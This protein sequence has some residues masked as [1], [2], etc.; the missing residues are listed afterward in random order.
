MK[1]VFFSLMLSLAG[2]SAMAQLKEGTV[3]YERKVNVHRTITDEQMRAMIPE[4]RTSKHMLMFSDSVSLFRLLPEDEAPDP[5]AGG[6]GGRVMFRFGGNTDGGD[7]YK[8]L[9]QSKSVLTAELA[10]KNYLI[11][12][13]IRQLPWKLTGETKQILGYT[14]LKATRKM[15]VSIAP[16]RRM[17]V[18]G[19][20]IS[21]NNSTEND[22]PQQKEIEVVAWYTEAIACPAGPDNNGQLPG[23]I[24]QLDSDNGATVYNAIEVKKNVDMKEL[25]EPKKGKIITQVEFNKLRADLMQQQMQNM[26]GGRNIRFGN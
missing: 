1:K 6:N 25:K 14:C 4:F 26:G 5:F 9:S 7:L 22:A 20:G 21:V 19:G 8:N 15:N 13:T 18:G 16:A 23:L 17:V 12:D 11:I 2:F 24:L 3:V 10:D